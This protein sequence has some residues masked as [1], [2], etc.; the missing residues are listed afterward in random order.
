M[1]SFSLE[2]CIRWKIPLTVIT[3]R[4]TTPRGRRATIST[5]FV[6]NHQFHSYTVFFYLGRG[7]QHYLRDTQIEVKQSQKGFESATHFKVVH[8]SQKLILILSCSHCFQDYPHEPYSSMDRI[9]MHLEILGS[10]SWSSN[11]NALR[12][13]P[14]FSSSAPTDAVC[15][16]SFMKWPTW[17]TLIDAPQSGKSRLCRVLRVKAN[18]NTIQWQILDYDKVS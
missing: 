18:Q 1:R 2:I 15:P 11:P 10:Q 13:P 8:N 6:T 7:H 17:T 5:S 4:A 9:T 12:G 16:A 14:P 3:S